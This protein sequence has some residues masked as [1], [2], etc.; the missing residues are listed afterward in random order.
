MSESPTSANGGTSAVLTVVNL[1]WPAVIHEFTREGQQATFG[2]STDCD[3]VIAVDPGDRRLSL[4]AGVIWRMHDELWL[5]NVSLSH[6]LYV[7]V[8]DLPPDP[9][10]SARRDETAR[11][12]AR[13]LPGDLAYIQGPGRCRLRVRQ[14]W[15]R[16][17]FTAGSVYGDQ[18]DAT[19]RVPPVPSDLRDVAAAMC[20]PLF[21]G[22]QLPASYAQIGRRTGTPSRKAVRNKVERLTSLYL[23]HIPALSDLVRERLEREAAM[24]G[25]PAA[26]TVSSSSR[27]AN[28]SSDLVDEAEQERRSALALPT[29]YEVA[30]FLVRR[31]LIGANE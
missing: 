7:D 15:S 4:R 12:A 22:S 13:Q 3:I 10:L 9:P 2:R 8:P 1:A 24:L 16:H 6:D 21:E 17:P 20:A 5:R 27:A 23:D 11:G 30:H 31:G 29:F 28:T 25:L 19:I 26:P 18:S 14:L